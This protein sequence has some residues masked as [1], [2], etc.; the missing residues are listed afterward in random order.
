MA[1]RARE[2]DDHRA[3]SEAVLRAAL[4]VDAWAGV[5]ATFAAR[6]PGTRP[7]L[8]G[9]DPLLERSVVEASS[10]YSDECVAAYRDYYHARNVHAGAWTKMRS[11]QAALARE[12]VPDRELASSE[13]Y[14]D[15]LR[16][17]G[18]LRGGGLIILAKDRERMV[19]FGAHVERR[20]M[21]GVEGPAMGMIRR[22]APLMRHALDV[23][24]MT[25][26]H[27]V[28]AVMLRRGVEPL[29]AA[30]L[31][32]SPSGSLL[33]ANGTAQRM[34]EAGTIVGTDA[35]GRLRFAEPS[36]QDRL[37]AALRS[38]QSVRP[39]FEAGPAESRREVRL[40]TVT[41]E[42]AAELRMSLFLQLRSPAMLVVLRRAPAPED[43]LARLCRRHGFTRAEGEVVLALSA[44]LSPAEVAEARAASIHTVRNQIK[45]AMAKAGVRRQGDLVR[46]V[47][48]PR[49]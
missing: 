36:A 12:M 39:S 24:R 2:D 25:L 31:L 35:R 20:A 40:V 28:D 48:D 45:S 47:S 17:Q 4:D 7:H 11:G 27:R 38:P 49:P 33:F 41:P 13:Y 34:I 9:W 21:A 8:V 5:A 10:G 22:L 19:L 1:G 14:N 6:F 30:L 3:L 42:M 37:V 43:E 15:W 44:G 26:R 32:V 18:D 29:G 46:S 16:P 23:N